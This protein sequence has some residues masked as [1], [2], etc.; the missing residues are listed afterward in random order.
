MGNYKIHEILKSILSL[1]KNENVSTTAESL[2]KLAID[3][4][5][6][7]SKSHNDEGTQDLSHWVGKGRWTDKDSWE[8]IGNKHYKMFKDICLLTGKKPKKSML[9]W[10]PGG[11]ANA[12]LFCK[13]FDE[14]Y[15]VDISNANLTECKH[16][17]ESRRFNK[18]HS[19]LI[20]PEKPEDCVQFISEPIDF[21]LSTA[22][23][24]HFPG[25]KY[26]LLVTKTA[27]KLLASGGLAI[28]QTRYDN[29]A[30]AFRSK[31]RDYNNN[32]I[33]FTSYRIEEFWQIAISCGFRPLMVNLEPD[34]NYA[35][36]LLQKRE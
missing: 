5:H 11:G 12:V 19:I 1:L 3:A 24:Q 35:Y 31:N 34:S 9:E 22:V 16:Q 10:G 26:G 27:Y 21:F 17:L 36:Y 23:Y 28:I 25:K 29:G 7:W 33:T 30:E 18:F 13:V 20:K 4:G 8:N 6:Y 2:P 14:Y 15:G 32:A